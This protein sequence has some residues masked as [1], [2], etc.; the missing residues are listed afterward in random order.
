MTVCLN[1]LYL[2]TFHPKNKINNLGKMVC[3]L[4]QSYLWHT[5]FYDKLNVVIKSLL[6]RYQVV[7]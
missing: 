6:N 2:R 3:N 4:Q 5:T 7:T 1:K